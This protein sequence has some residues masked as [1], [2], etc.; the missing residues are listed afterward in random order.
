MHAVLIYMYCRLVKNNKHTVYC[1]VD[2]QY[3]KNKITV[4]YMYIKYTR[5]HDKK[6]RINTRYIHEK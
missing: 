2:K 1:F 6:I 3:M 5:I 4:I